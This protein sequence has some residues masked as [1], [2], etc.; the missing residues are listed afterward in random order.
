M[1]FVLD[2]RLNKPTL[3]KSRVDGPPTA[4]VSRNTGQNKQRTETEDKK[5]PKTQPGDRLDDMPVTAEAP[6]QLKPVEVLP[7]DSDAHEKGTKQ[8]QNQV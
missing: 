1:F 2:F 4:K 7:H 3:T 5:F 6:H 8:S